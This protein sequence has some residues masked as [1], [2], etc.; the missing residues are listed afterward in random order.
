MFSKVLLFFQQILAPYTDFHYRHN[1]DTPEGQLKWVCCFKDFQSRFCHWW[2]K[3]ATFI[4]CMYGCVV[5]LS[6]EKTGRLDFWPVRCQLL[7]PSA[8]GQVSNA[9][10]FCGKL[11]GFLW[12][13]CSPRFQSILKVDCVTVY[14]LRWCDTNIVM[15]HASFKW[16]FLMSALLRPN[17][18]FCPTVSPGIINLCKSGNSGIQS[19]IGLLCIPNTEVRVWQRI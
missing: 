11:R 10:K 8:L 3:H 9:L 6:T 5:F 19:L 7:L 14:I 12:N 15:H 16:N 4:C 1:P 2:H 17:L 13:P 18:L